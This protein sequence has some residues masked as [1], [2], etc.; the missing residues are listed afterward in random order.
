[1]VNHSWLADFQEYCLTNGIP[2]VSY[3]LPREQTPV[4]LISN[5]G[6]QKFDETD[7]HQS[8]F[9]MAPFLKN[10]AK[11]WL[12][13]DQ[14]LTGEKISLFDLEAI[15]PEAYGKNN[16]LNDDLLP[17]TITKQAY[18]DKI[19]RL[20]DAINSGRLNKVVL[21]RPVL[22][23]FN[24]M[25]ESPL[26]F[27]QLIKTLPDAFIYLLSF[28]GAGTWLG[29]SPELLLKANFHSTDE[30]ATLETMALAGT[31]QSGS[32][33]EW[34]IK[35]I[36]E[37]EWVS[38]YI[39]QKLNQSGCFN[40]EQEKTHTI[41]AG[42]VEHLRTDFKALLNRSRIME[43]ADELHPTPAVCGW[44]TITALESIL[45]VE[46]YDRS[47]YTGYLG[48][49]NLNSQ[50]SLFVNLRCM[51]IAE[52]NASLYVGGGITSGSDPLKEWEETIIKSHTLLAQIEKI[53]NLAS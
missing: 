41:A 9:I 48:P 6:V 30:P 28:P 11:L 32:H 33:K 53:R 8:G 45:S 20:K 15:K 22:T 10:R 29:A 3:R 37:Q 51:Q 38:K 4:T 26:I 7:L 46:N 19:S 5:S 36:D 23:G 43:L 34:G 18:L 21:S 44:P 39:I 2:F 52:K 12:K 17:Q 24:R 49:V 47:F 31:R 16:I 25:E 1:M 42:N 40:I 27:N 50:T 13:A 14:I 35:E